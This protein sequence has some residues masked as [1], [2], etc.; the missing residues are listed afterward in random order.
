MPAGLGEAARPFHREEGLVR[1]HGEVNA[2][3]QVT[4]R[5]IHVGFALFGL[6][7]NVRITYG[8]VLAH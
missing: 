6:L 8:C 1:V 2:G 7:D 4:C 3:A 5:W